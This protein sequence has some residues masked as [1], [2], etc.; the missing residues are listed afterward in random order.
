MPEPKTY[1][2]PVNGEYTKILESAADTNGEYSHLEVCLKPGGGNPP[3]YHKKFTEEF[4][5]VKGLLGL[6]YEKE[7]LHLQPGENRLVPIG[8]VHRFFNNTDE[9]IIFRIILRKGQPGFE[10][11]IKSLFGLVNDEKTTKRQTPKNP[12][13]AALLLK[14]GDTHLKNPFFYLL[15]PFAGMAYFLAKV[16]GADTR[17]K[18]RYCR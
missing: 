3:H 16:T 7:D 9:E 14:W 12:L 10:N 8:T 13:Y 18:N 15:T 17:L 2:N 11:F 1:Y 4:F 5:A 6:Q